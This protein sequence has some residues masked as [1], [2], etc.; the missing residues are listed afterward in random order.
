MKAGQKDS[1]HAK[2]ALSVMPGM[3][4]HFSFIGCWSKAQV[5]F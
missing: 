1:D 2:P 3:V 5:P 4:D